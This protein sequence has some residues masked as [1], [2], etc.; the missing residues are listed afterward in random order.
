VEQLQP[1]RIDRSDLL[2]NRVLWAVHSY[3][4]TG[5]ANNCIEE[6]FGRSPSAFQAFWQR[7]LP[8]VVPG[9]PN[10]F[11]CYCFPLPLRDGCPAWV[12][13]ESC[14][15]DYG[16]AYSIHHPSWG[17]SVLVSRYPSAYDWPRFRW[18]EAVLIAE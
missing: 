18:E 16:I 4:Q 2:A 14:P 1:K 17:S 3:E 7:E 11:P 6:F 13:Y 12:E 8:S 9:E 15:G 5:G 10:L